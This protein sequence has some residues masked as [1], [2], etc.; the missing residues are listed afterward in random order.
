ALDLRVEGNAV[1]CTL[2]FDAKASDQVMDH[3]VASFQK[4]LLDQDLRATVRAETKEV[5]NLILAHAFSRTGLI[6]D[7]PLPVD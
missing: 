6:G 3:V 7:E 5:R 4:E 1:L 2:T